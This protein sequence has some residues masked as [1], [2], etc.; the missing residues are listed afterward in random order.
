MRIDMH[1]RG[2]DKLLKA[3]VDQRK[4]TPGYQ[5]CSLK[6]CLVLTCSP[7]VQNGDIYGRGKGAV[8]A[9]QMTDAVWDFVFL[10]GPQ[11]QADIDPALLKV[12]ATGI[13]GCR[14][15]GG[16]MASGVCCSA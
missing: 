2:K 10:D 16:A 13:L 12:R 6:A 7:H 11:P 15:A 5:V 9:E 4:R 8:R 1:L 14:S 3:G